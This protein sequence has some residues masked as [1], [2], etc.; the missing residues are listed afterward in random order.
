MISLF[1]LS[2]LFLGW[3]LGANDAANVIGTAVGTRMLRFRTAALIVSLFV[4][5]GAVISG[6]GASGTLGRLGA[7]DALAGSFTVAL[8]AAVTVTWMTRA[9]LPVSVSQAIVGAIVGWNLFTGV[10][11][12]FNVLGR[13]LATWVFCPVLAAL[14]AVLLFLPARALLERLRIHLLELDAT[15]RA[16]LILAAAFGAYSLG[17]NNIANVM[18]VFVSASAMPNLTLWGLPSLDSTRQLFLLGALA[19]AVGVFTYSRRTIGTVGARLTRLTPMTALIVV[20]AQSLVLF[21]FASEGLERWLVTRGLPTLPLVPVSSSH[22][23]VGA[24]I[25]IGLAKGARGVNMRVLGRIAQGWVATPVAAALL[26]WAALF[27]MQNV[28]ELRVVTPQRYEV[29]PAVL[30]HLASRG[31]VIPEVEALSG[32][33]F[34]S[35]ASFRRALPATGVFRREPR[36]FA[37]MNAAEVHVTRIDSLWLP[38]RLDTSRFGAGA[39]AAI[40]R[41]HGESFRHRW[42]LNEALAAQSEAWRPATGWG[43][44]AL[45]KEL[46]RMRE[47]VQRTFAEPAD[48]P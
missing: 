7:V 21:L 25:G 19:I 6:A 1:L 18:G 32:S 8:A 24:I 34:T 31:V 13:I 16:L 43:H 5:L 4:I 14:L 9:R 2:G 17:A 30:E 26:S 47:D 10:P 46:N 42:Q 40:K 45:N 29:T 27:F 3:S 39:L 28:F 38:A 12:D 35:A 41:L 44:Q 33:T 20:V 11:T 15:T 22:A 36:M 37:V 23:V 48:S